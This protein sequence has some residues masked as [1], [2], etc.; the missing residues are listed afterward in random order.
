MD[1]VGAPEF[2][3]PAARATTIK[4]SKHNVRM[5]GPGGWRIRAL[6]E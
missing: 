1:D 3:H 4:P 2:E 6:W 5:A